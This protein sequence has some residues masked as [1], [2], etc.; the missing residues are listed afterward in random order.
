MKNKMPKTNLVSFIIV[1]ENAIKKKSSLS[2]NESCSVRRTK[3]VGGKSFFLLFAPNVS[4]WRQ[5]FH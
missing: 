4:L 2:L 5:C 3:M 1:R